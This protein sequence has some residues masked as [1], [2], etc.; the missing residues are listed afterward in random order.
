MQ[1]SFVGTHPKQQ[2]NLLKLNIY[3]NYIHSKSKRKFKN[4]H[5]RYNQNIIL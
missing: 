5:A 1:Q 4:I 3:E 2:Q